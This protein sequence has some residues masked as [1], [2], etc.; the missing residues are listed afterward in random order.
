MEERAETSE[1][2]AGPITERHAAHYREHGYAIVENFLSPAELAGALEEWREILPGW[3]E[4]CQDAG[5]PKPGEALPSGAKP[6]NQSNFRFPYPGRHLN[7]ITTHPAL[8]DF[9]G[10]MA[11]GSEMT[12]EQ[13]H[14]S[15]KLAGQGADLEQAMHCDYGN[16]TLAYPPDDPA[17]W[18]T[19]YLLYYTDVTADHAP[20]AVCSRRHYPERILWPAHYTREKRPALYENEVKVV[21]PAGSLFIYSMRTFHRGTAFRAD[22]G[23]LAQFI[24]YA[25][26][27]W[28]WLGIVGWSAQAIKP[29]FRA[30]V[31]QAT[32]AER[33]LFGFPPPGHV[34]WTEETLDGVSARYPGMDMTPYRARP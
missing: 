21:V 25:P 32:P 16:H 27:A 1:G 18:Q 29:A 12:C 7:A 11:G 3:V 13:S 8:V 26:A 9:A 2:V 24:T 28:Q 22:A 14:L 23:R 30:W 6:L 31:E 5:A 33:E 20:T 10:C 15:F 19:A 17:Y 4:F 34:Y